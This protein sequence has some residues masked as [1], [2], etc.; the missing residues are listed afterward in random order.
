MHGVNS[1]EAFLELGLGY[2]LGLGL[3]LGLGLVCEQVINQWWQESEHNTCK[4]SPHHQS[5]FHM[6]HSILLKSLV[7]YWSKFDVVL[8][9]VCSMPPACNASW[10]LANKPSVNIMAN[11]S[12]NTQPSLC[13]AMPLALGSFASCRVCLASCW[14]G[15]NP[16]KIHSKAKTKINPSKIKD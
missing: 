4:W 13:F 16:K 6:T 15:T 11:Q 2:D 1:L 5:I 14:H 12:P 9:W 7:G 10:R 3:A 8:V